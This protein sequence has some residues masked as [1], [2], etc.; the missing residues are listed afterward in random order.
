MEAAQEST[1]RLRFGDLAADSYGTADDRP[2][3]VLLHGLTYDRR[4]WQPVVHQ[5]TA[6]DPGRRILAFDLPGH[7]ES[8]PR[9]SY[10]TDDVAA[11]IHEA[12]TAAGLDAPIV[13][14]HSLSGVLATIYAATYP[15]RG[16]VN[17]DQPLLVGNFGDV[18]RRAEPTLRSPDYLTVWNSLLAHMHVDL[19]PSAAKELVTTATTPAQ[20]LLLGYWSEVLRTPAEEITERR[21][22]DLEAIRSRAI[23]YH[24]IS[25]TDLDPAYHRWLESVLPDV[26]ITVLP[27]GGHFPHLVHPL[28]VAEILAA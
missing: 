9:A 24:V 14:G 19:L 26:E 15:V 27:G 17:V 25:G 18:L 23:P 28:T 2:P 3:L 11:V 4:Q 20:D 10:Q 8:Q 7:G 16:A 13:V 22:R 12:V 21:V 5:L 1:Q 6:L